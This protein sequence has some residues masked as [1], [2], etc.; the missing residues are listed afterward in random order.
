M[1]IPVTVNGAR[2]VEGSDKREPFSETTQTVL[3]FGNGAVIRLSSS[4]TPGQLLFLT[5]EKTKK[6]VVCQV[7][8]SKNYSNV[9]GYVELEFTEAVSGFWGVRFAAEGPSKAGAPG[10]APVASAPKVQSSSSAATSAP[11]QPVAAAPVNAAKTENVTG[12]APKIEIKPP[13]TQP[14][15]GEAPSVAGL[16]KPPAL[17]NSWGSGSASTNSHAHE[18]KAPAPPPVKAPSTPPASQAHLSGEALKRESARLQEQLSA[19]LFNTGEPAAAN[20]HANVESVSKV[21]EMT[22]SQPPATKTT[23]PA[24]S[25]S[26][27]DADEVKIPSWLEPLARNA[28]TPAQNELVTEAPESDDAVEYEVQDLSAPANSQQLAVVP[29]PEPVLNLTAGPEFPVRERRPARNNKVILIAAAAAG[30][31]VLAA[32]TTW[33]LRQAPSASSQA[34]VTA[35]APSSIAAAQPVTKSS[36]DAPTGNASN[37]GGNF[38]STPSGL[39]AVASPA[40]NSQPATPTA[41]P[42]KGASERNTAAELSAYR[43]LAEP[44]QPVQPQSKKTSLGEV[45]LA[46]PSAARR[47]AVQ[48]AG[49]IELAPTIGHVAPTGDALGGGLA[50]GGS[51]PVAP[52]APLPVGGDVK[53]AKLI[54]SAPPV[55]P[56]LAKTQHIEGNVRIDALVDEGGKVSLMKVV[57]GPTLLQQAAMDAVRQWKYQPATLDGKAVPM[58]LTVTLQFRLQ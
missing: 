14:R 45:R 19:M 35:E 10:S 44:P 21:I 56:V 31:L 40:V 36:A 17:P 30:F 58:H 25:G 5:N 11:K 57:S 24:K 42:L 48:E 53:Q 55:Y 4:V 47:P 16:P 13:A 38:S 7:L 18:V 49:G 15:A 20:K 46:A 2:T 6:E 9:S 52:S 29:A 54:S 39:S 23:S 28:A 41:Q 22:K 51:K 8:K 32:G 26:G 33:Y 27:L 43:K 50:G 1:E 3:V 34:A 12:S 37:G